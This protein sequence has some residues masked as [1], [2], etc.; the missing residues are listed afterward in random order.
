MRIEK[1][2]I[3]LIVGCAVAG[4]IFLLIV[5]KGALVSLPVG[6]ASGAAGGAVAS[7]FRRVIKSN[8]DREK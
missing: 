2:D 1:I 7:I 5:S 6:L 3:L 8:R 4:G